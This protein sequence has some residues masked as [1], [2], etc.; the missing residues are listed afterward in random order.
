MQL[1]AASAAHQ[2]RQRNRNRNI[3]R[4]KLPKN[5]QQGKSINGLRAS[6]CQAAMPP[7]QQH[8]NQMKQQ[9]LQRNTAAT[10]RNSKTEKG[11]APCRLLRL[12][13]HRTHH[14]QKITKETQQKLTLGTEPK[15]KPHHAAALR[16]LRPF[17]LADDRMDVARLDHAAVGAVRAVG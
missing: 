11:T 2:R 10:K 14:K 8:E 1:T 16:P 12:N 15:K 6:A 13:Y 5:T 4:T 7:G 9:N 3:D 17:S